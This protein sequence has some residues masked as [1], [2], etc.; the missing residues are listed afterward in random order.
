MSADVVG[1]VRHWFPDVDPVEDAEA[2]VAPLL[3]FNR[4][5]QPAERWR[6]ADVDVV[7]V[8]QQGA[9]LWGRRA[10]GGFVE[11]AS[12]AAAWRSVETRSDLF[13]L[14]HAAFEALWCSPAVRMAAKLDAVAIGRLLGV[15]RLL[16]CA[17]W[18]WPG[19]RATLFTCGP[20][21]VMVCQ[22]RG[23]HWVVAAGRCEEDLAELDA[24][25][26]EWDEADTSI[27]PL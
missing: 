8:E 16:P 14:H 13:W 24:L 20:A 15:S 18:H 11:R 5:L 26:L 27:A 6:E 7:V 22:D 4:A 12:Q 23:A 10:D 9:W 1:F 2:L 21:L 25:D 19:D 17:P 3:A